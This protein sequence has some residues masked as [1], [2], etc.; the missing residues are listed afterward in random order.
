MHQAEMTSV[1]K[2]KRGR[3]RSVGDDEGQMKERLSRRDQKY[4][5]KVSSL[6]T[7]PLGTS[8]DFS[9]FSSNW[10][11]NQRCLASLAAALQQSNLEQA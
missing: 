11:T 8:I 3:K 1:G 4:A 5:D 6:A 10:P 9:E 2:K 7:N